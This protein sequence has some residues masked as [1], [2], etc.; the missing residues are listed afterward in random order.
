MKKLI[1]ISLLTAL[2]SY[3]YAQKAPIRYGKPTMEQM[4]KSVYEIDSTAPAIVLCNYGYFDNNQFRF[5][6]TIRIKILKKEGYQWANRTF[7]SGSSAM[8]R[9]KTF[10]LVDG[11][12]VT[13]KLSSKSIFRQEVIKNRLYVTKISMPNVKVGSVIDIEVI[14]PWIPMA[15]YFQETIP[16]LY[17]ELVLE[18]N[19][20]IDFTKNSFGYVG[21]YV[22]EP[23]RWVTKNVPAFQK[24]PFM[25]PVNNYLAHF[26]FDVT[27]FSIPGRVYESFARTWDDVNETLGKSRSFGGALRGSGSFFG[28]MAKAIN[29]KYDNN[30]DKLKAAVDTIHFM[31]WDG[32][33]RLYAT[34]DVGLSYHYHKGK[35]NSAD[36]N[37]ALIRLLGKIGFEVHPVVLRTRDKGRISMFNPTISNLNYVVAYVKVNDNYILVDATDKK[38]PYY[39]LPDRCLNDQGRLVSLGNS[40]WVPLSNNVKHQRMA[41]YILN[42]DNDDL[43]LK[44]NVT[45]LYKGYAAYHFRKDYEEAGTNDNYIDKLTN[46]LEGLRVIN[47]TLLFLE[48]V[49]KPVKE[50]AT[51]EIQ[52]QCFA[53]DSL[54]YVNLLPERITENPFK[55]EKRKYPIDFIYPKEY[56]TT[57]IITVPDN[58]RVVTIPASK[59]I[60]LPEN[61]ASFTYMIQQRGNKLT[62]IYSLKI[63]K[64]FFLQ[65][66]YELLKAFYQQAIEKENEPVVF[67]VL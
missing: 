58:Y 45:Y 11:K 1:F 9:G 13:D 4:T 10:N 32:D 48:D 6:H 27:G 53:N 18:K 7:N 16:V 47:D 52:N 25:A 57:V 3:L 65:E 56:K 14:Y 59:R 35:G 39:I 46:S 2:T 63:N 42:L 49:Y 12:I 43:N 61:A 8:V 33:N 29:A 64:S 30:V 54:V 66:E 37:L 38:A 21:F 50:K 24:E 51:I 26:E 20:Y 60:K 36:I 34:D 15:W 22:V 19:Q 62:L 55:Q 41:F 31:H 67:K 44:G 28:T 40:G 23:D 5:I 17:S